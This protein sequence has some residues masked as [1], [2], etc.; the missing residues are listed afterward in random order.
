MAPHGGNVVLRPTAAMMAT[1]SELRC[2]CEDHFHENTLYR[3]NL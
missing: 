1:V 2:K 3:E